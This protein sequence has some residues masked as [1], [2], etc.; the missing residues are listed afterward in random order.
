MEEKMNLDSVVDRD[1][2]NFIP[3]KMVTI[4]PDK[5]IERFYID[6]YLEKTEDVYHLNLISKENAIDDLKYIIKLEDPNLK[7]IAWACLGG[8]HTF[9]GNYA[10]AFAAFQIALDQHV[11]EDVKSYI[12]TELSNLLRKLGYLKEAIAL[13]D[14]S[15]GK[16]KNKKLKWRIK[17]YRGLSFNY[18]EPEYALTLLTDSADHYR[19]KGES[20]RLST[21]LRHMGLI[22]VFIQDFK[23]AQKYFD[24]ALSIAIE[25]SLTDHQNEVV[26]DRG[27]MFIQQQEYNKARELFNK[28]IQTDLSP[29][30][31]SLGLQNIGY[32]EFNRENYREAIKFHSQSLQLTSK[33]EMRDMAIEDYYKLGLCHEKL[34]ER[35][36]ADHFYF[37]GYQEIKQEVDI[38]LPVLGYRN[39][40]L[41]AYI[42][43]LR[44]NQKIPHIEID[45][46]IF[47][48]ALNKTLKEIRNIFH[49]HLFNLHLERSKS[50]IILCRNL[51]INARTYFLYQ[52]KLGLKRGQLQ[53]K[54][55]DENMYFFEYVES[56][57]SLT[58]REANGKFEDD[59]MRYLLGK[60]QY[61]KKKLA[62]A[63]GV[64]YA[65]IS[66]KTKPERLSL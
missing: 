39:N 31:M 25:H 63:L 16:T 66:I 49:K 17:T 22:S 10:K 59:L 34:G 43:F 47:G 62:D 1:I 40:L 14:A 60:Y 52:K 15:L 36:L 5:I 38:G 33:Y 58:W 35:A 50:A 24:E 12:F 42:E 53:K 6:Q 44:T 9:N 3:W 28:H 29:Y 56:L 26:N 11:V 41:D 46:E 30:L 37:A 55:S 18:T 7:G 2:R 61:N 19:E 51:K 21:V 48:F 8:L 27:W 57:T 64:S 13:L 20:F 4:P 65:L 23:S 32:L 45:E 54:P